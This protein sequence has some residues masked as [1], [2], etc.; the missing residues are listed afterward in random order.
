MDEITKELGVPDIV[1]MPGVP[2][3]MARVQIMWSPPVVSVP[4]TWKFWGHGVYARPPHPTESPIS[5]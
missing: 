2:P 5:Q 3:R 1:L 4:K